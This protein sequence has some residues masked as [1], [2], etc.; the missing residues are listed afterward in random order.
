MEYERVVNM[1][2]YLKENIEN[3][4]N[5]NWKIFLTKGNDINVKSKTWEKWRSKN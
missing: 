4:L 5:N 1:L 2:E 3:K